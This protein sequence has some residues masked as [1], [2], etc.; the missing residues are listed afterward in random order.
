M[1]RF[2]RM[3]AAAAA[4]LT[5]GSLLLAGC[6]SATTYHPAT[7][8]G[9]S[10]EGFSDQQLEADRFRVTFSGNTMTSRD[11]V[12]RYLLFRA[13]ELTVQQGGTYFVLADRDT[14][15]QSRTYATPSFSPYGGYAGFGWWGPRWRY[16]GRGF[17]W[18][19]WDPLFGDPFFGDTIDVQT[20]DRYEASAEIIIGRGAKP[21]DNVRAFDARSVID[22]LGPSIVVPTDR[23]R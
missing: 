13:A 9:F 21:V 6:M 16:Y 20:V 14:D 4:T 11:T 23:R 17:G 2:T 7:G 19:G 10:R 1:S 8:Q 12:E 3:R 15:R 5:A 18:R 22:H